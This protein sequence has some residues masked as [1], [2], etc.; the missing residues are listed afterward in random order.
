[1]G[2][3]TVGKQPIERAEQTGSICEALTCLGALLWLPAERRIL[4]EKAHHFCRR[5][6]LLACMT[7]HRNDVATF[8]DNQKPGTIRRWVLQKLACVQTSTAA[9]AWI[10]RVSEPI[11]HEI[12]TQDNRE[13]C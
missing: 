4:P 5:G 7:S 11:S 9:G 13:Y 2:L 12:G 10:K 8:G 1:M 6:R 3:A